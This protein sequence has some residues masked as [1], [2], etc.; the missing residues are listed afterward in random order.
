MSNRAV[1]I[2]VSIAEKIDLSIDRAQELGCVGTFQIFTCSPRRWAAKP[3]NSEQVERFKEKIS[4]SKFEPFAHMPYMPN[5]SSPDDTFYSG[6]VEVLVREIKRCSLLGV[7]GLVL[8][9]GSH[10]G[11]SIEDGQSRI[12][13]GC[14]KAIKSTE[15]LDVRLLLENSAESRNSVGAKFEYIRRVLDGISDRSRTGVCFDT[16]HAFS[17]GYDLRDPRA[18]RDT[19]EQFE[20]IVGIEKLFLIHI[21]DSKFALG[22]GRD[23]HEHIGKGKIGDKGFEALFALKEIGSV[24]LVLETPIDE[25]IGDKEDV[26]HTKKLLHMI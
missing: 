16:C 26:A 21:N 17:S 6:S 22:E 15:G 20:K 18:A 11:S 8:H 24:P 19:F 1:G 12:I 5:L 2:H 4:I 13:R 14:K 23:R 25:K 7:K 9:F 3:L 10:M